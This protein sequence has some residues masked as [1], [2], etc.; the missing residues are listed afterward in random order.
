MEVDDSLRTCHN[1]DVVPDSNIQEIIDKCIYYY[2]RNN[3]N[4]PPNDEFSE[5]DNCLRL[6]GLY[7]E[8]GNRVYEITTIATTSAVLKIIPF[9]AIDETS[10]DEKESKCDERG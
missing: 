10:M 7:E 4:I 8:E 9:G 1:A 5:W 3:G 2:T 6:L